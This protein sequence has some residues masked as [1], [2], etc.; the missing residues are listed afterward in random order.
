MKRLEPK[1]TSQVV[2]SIGTTFLIGTLGLGTSGLGFVPAY[3]RPWADIEQS[4][5]LRVGVKTD[6]P[7]LAWQDESGE[8]QGLEIAITRQLANQLLGDENA[9][10]FVPLANQERVE[11]VIDDRVDMAIAQ[12]GITT[13][14]I[15]RVNLTLPYYLD[16]TAIVVPDSSPLS[17]SLGLSTEAIAVLQDSTAVAT[18]NT[19]SPELETVGTESYLDSV[20]ALQIGRVDG[21]AA[22]ASVMAG[23]VQEEAGY[24]LL[25]PL[26]SGS[27]LAIALPKGNQYSELRRRV[28]VEMQELA[29]SGWF[30][31][32]AEAWGLP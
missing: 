24:R 26:L 31:Q 29:D 6:L 2:L 20:D 19:L 17:S 18:L 21:V 28:N 16:G 27:G 13:A 7:P 32:Q 1:A 23:W 10:E 8:W 4:G 15:R 30:E 12:I 9:V 14:R 22:D 25:T 5:R 3:S 11:A